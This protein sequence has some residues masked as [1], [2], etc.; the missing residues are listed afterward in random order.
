MC[1]VKTVYTKG[2]RFL[3][4]KGTPSRGG[5]WEGGEGGRCLWFKGMEACHARGKE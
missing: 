1:D 5:H 4:E 3:V 2:G